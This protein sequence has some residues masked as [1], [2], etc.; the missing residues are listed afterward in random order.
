MTWTVC[1][2]FWDI[3]LSITTTKNQLNQPLGHI[4]ITVQASYGALFKHRMYAPIAIFAFT[5][6]VLKVLFGCV[7][8]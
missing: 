1:R 3:I 4:V 7:H 6:N 8:M 5:I 2:S